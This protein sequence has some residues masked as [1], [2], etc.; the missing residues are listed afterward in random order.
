MPFRRRP[1]PDL[2]LIAFLLIFPLL[3]FHQQTLGDRTL[4]PSENLFQYLPYSTYREVAQAPAIPHNHL[5]S[6]LVLQNYQWKSFIRD[7]IS[8][9]EIPLWNP[10]LFSGI[11]FFAAGQHSALYPLSVVYYLLPLST[12]YG[13]FILLN[14]W[15][16]GLFMAGF[17]RALGVNRYGA[18]LGGLVYQLSGFMIA[19]AVF[20]MIVAGAVWLPL[21]LWMVENVLRGRTLWVFRGTAIPWVSIGAIALACS[22]LAGHVEIT[23]Y[24]LLIVVP[25]FAYRLLRETLRRWREAGK[26]P[27]RWAGVSAFWLSLMVLLGLGLSAL[28]LIPMY[29]FVASNWRSERASL[30]TVLGYAHPSRDALQFLLPN[31]YGSPAHHSY[32][33]AFSGERVSDLRNLAGE[34]IHYIDWGIK[35]YVEAAL[36]LGILP[37]LL[38]G[39]ALIA[40]IRRR[41]DAASF[42]GISIFLAILAVLALSFMF[43]A[44][45]YALVFQLPGMNQLNSPF[46]WVFALT[47]AVAALAGIGFHLLSD[48]QNHS[49]WSLTW[50]KFIGVILLLLG[51]G[52][53]LGAGIS[54]FYYDQFAPFFDGMVSSLAGAESAFA[55]GR[56]FYSYQLPQLVTLAML[57]L[58]SGVIFLWAAWS[59]SGLWM[60]LALVMIG[61][62]LLLATYAFNPASDPL[63]LDFKPPAVEFLQGQPGHF[64]ITSLEA[65]PAQPA[66]L[67]PNLGMSY[68]LDDIRGYDSIIPGGYVATMRALQPQHQLDFNRISPVYTTPGWNY[69][70]GFEA[71]LHADLFNL[72]NIKYVL[73]PRDWQSMPVGWNSV[74][75]DEAVTIW[76]NQSVMPRAFIVDKADWDPRWLAEQGGGFH[77]GEFIT[78]STALHVPLYQEA[79]ITRDTAREKFIDVRVEQDSWLVVSESYMPGWRA[80]ARLR[81]AG[82]DAEFGLAVRLV[83]ANLQ[84]VELPAGEWTVRLVYS[85]ASVHLGMFGSAISVALNGVAGGKLVLARIHRHEYR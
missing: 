9:G 53:G 28:Q 85:P 52:L 32:F 62:D 40:G 76:E 6:D 1:P 31:F 38:A 83:L 14:L 78:P 43:G 26:W 49:R 64:R 51:I 68:G 69:S 56:M 4:L 81:S 8:Q 84:G 42:A 2:F 18:A 63:L 46:R 19:S 57:L 39:F 29:E 48:R 72:L 25:Y 73:T 21:I 35:N 23:I 67:L 71:V 34:T 55:N 80:F 65:D 66:I 37:L 27:W 77:F 41:R 24:T 54:F 33:D 45:T 12:A 44:R 3:M 36:Y 82:E 30:E 17:L 61:L 11:P 15:L 70:G 20:P 16:A 59:R 58:M 74:Y 10:H 7:Q 50:Q 60:V 47:F 22:V 5:L 75:G 13:W 79:V